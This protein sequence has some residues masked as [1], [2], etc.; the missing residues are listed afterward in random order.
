[1][2]SSKKFNRRARISFDTTKRNIRK[3]FP[4]II[5]GLVV[6]LANGLLTVKKIN[7]SLNDVS[8]PKEIETTLKKLIGTDSLFINQKELLTFIKAVYPVDE[9][10]VDYKA[11]NTI[12]INLHGNSPFVQANVYFVNQLPVLSMDQAPSTTDSASW[13]KKPTDELSSFISSQPP[14]GFNL[15]E[16]GSMTPSATCGANINFIF[17]EKPTAESVS[18]IFKMLT[19]V[20]KYID[21]STIYIVNDRSFLSRPGQPDI[22][23]G[24]PFDEESLVSAL[25]S[26]SYLAT[27][28]KDARVIDLSFKD[29]IIR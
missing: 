20:N 22:I 27:I 23:V 13:W 14:L 21:V 28:K 7:C 1:M 17:S 12:S 10:T 15:W 24:V 3:V 5:L 8:C 11:F 29:P 18:S 6:F 9:M 16:N 4:I 25:Q 26:I 19:I 2:N